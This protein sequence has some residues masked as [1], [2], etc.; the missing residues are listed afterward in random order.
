V[1]VLIYTC[2]IF[3][4]KAKT[5]QDSCNVAKEAEGYSIAIASRKNPQA[6]LRQ[7]RER[8]MPRDMQKPAV[9]Q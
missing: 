1:L 4:A 9:R 8:I 5:Y 6:L 2:D 3:A 7:A